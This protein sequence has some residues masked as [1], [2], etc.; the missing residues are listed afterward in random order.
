MESEGRYLESQISETTSIEISAQDVETAIEKGLDRL[1]ITRDEAV[2]EILDEGSAGFLG[3]GGR[4]ASV[5]I[6]AKS[7]HAQV[8]EAALDIKVTGAGDEVLL[9]E[10][11]E[12]AD[13]KEGPSDK[14]QSQEEKLAIEIIDQLLDKMNIDATT[15]LRQTEPDDLTGEQRWVI[16]IMGEDLGLLIG[17]RGDTLNAFQYVA[18]LMTSHETHRRSSF[19]VDVEGYRERREQALARLAGRMAGKAIKRGRVVTLEPMP[20]NERR[21]IHITLRQDDRVYTESIDE[22]Q[23]RRVKIVPN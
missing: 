13:W 17:S 20:P 18:R 10:Q 16:D 8:E 1:G 6:S 23:R 9:E 4:D 12:L 3:I 15:S 2:I 14:D 7:G 22:G 19:L 11:D 21:I 5:K